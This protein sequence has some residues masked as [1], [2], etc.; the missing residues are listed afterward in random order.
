MGMCKPSGGINK[1]EYGPFGKNIK[2]VVGCT[3]NSRTDYF[4]EVTGKL[5]QQR[6]YDAD[7]KAEWDRDWSHG[8]SNNTHTFPHDYYWDWEKNKVH[9]PRPEYLAP[10][11]EKT[12]KNYC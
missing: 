5:L 2:D 9:P 10:N 11:G 3:P 7:G 12:N 1:P 6:W 4:D 8:D